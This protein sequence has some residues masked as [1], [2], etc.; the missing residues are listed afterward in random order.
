MDT[1]IK[2]TGLIRFGYRDYDP[3]IGRWTA[4]DPIGFEGGD[5]N[6]YGYVLGDPVNFVD[7]N[8]LWSV[9]IKAHAGLGGSVTLGWSPGNGIF[10]SL[11]GGIGLDAGASF[12]PLDNSPF[13]R[14]LREGPYAAVCPSLRTG[15]RGISV[16]G[17]A[18]IGVSAY[19]V[20]YGAGRGRHFLDGTSASYSEKPSFKF[21]TN[22][23]ESNIGF[24]V[25]G[26]ANV[27]I[28]L[29]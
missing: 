4:R 25:G 10:G 2:D 20:E 11:Q 14:E 13:D 27:E 6:L 12:A 5:S 29:W 8:G 16:G 9:S 15:K 19:G 23:F 3:E 26:S 28:I 18:Q 17:N 22:V 7:S 21:G 24:S 1:S